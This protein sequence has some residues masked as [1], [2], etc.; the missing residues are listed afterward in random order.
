MLK[1]GGAHEREYIIV[2]DGSKDNSS[3]IIKSL[4]K[5]LPGKVILLRRK[6]M[7]ASYS[8]N[9]AVSLVRG[10]W[11]RLLDGDDRVTY[12]STENMLNLATRCK[13][14][15]DFGNKT[16]MSLKKTPLPDANNLKNKY[17]SGETNDS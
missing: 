10:F 2:D 6:N 11:I 13:T 9:E 14:E 7:G 5:K 12:K 3:F 8:T 4:L 16:T 1:E 17:W 15:F